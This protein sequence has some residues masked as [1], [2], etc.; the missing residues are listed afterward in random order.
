MAWKT[1]GRRKS[2]PRVRLSIAEKAL[3]WHSARPGDRSPS[4]VRGLNQ[5]SLSTWPVPCRKA[6]PDPVNATESATELNPRS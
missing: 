4:F 1:R 3:A 2:E 5:A 6:L